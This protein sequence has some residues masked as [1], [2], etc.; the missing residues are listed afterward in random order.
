MNVMKNHLVKF[1]ASPNDL[2]ERSAVNANVP[3]GPEI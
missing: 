1:G 3:G 2:T